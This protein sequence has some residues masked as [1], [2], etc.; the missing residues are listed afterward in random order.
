MIKT[1]ERKKVYSPPTID[2]ILVEMEQGIAAQS[3]SIISTDVDN[4]I[5]EEWKD[6]KEISTEFDW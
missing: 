5:Y 6:I 1:Q 4:E 3:S 2:I